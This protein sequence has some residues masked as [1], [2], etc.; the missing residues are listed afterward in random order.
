MGRRLPQWKRLLITATALF[1]GSVVAYFVRALSGQFSIEINNILFWVFFCFMAVLIEGLYWFNHFLNQRLPFKGNI[2]RRIAVQMVSG[3][4]YALTLRFLLYEL[5]EPYITV[6]LDSMFLAATWFLYILGS[7]IVNS[8]FFLD[9]FIDQWKESLIKAERLD[10]EKT[11]VQFDNLKNQLNPHFLFNALTS[12]NSLIFENQGLA[13]QFLQHLSKVYRYV[14]QNKGKNFVTVQ[15]ELDFIQNY[16]FLLRTRF[17]SALTISF[18]IDDHSKD[19][20]IV[21]V[22]LQILIEN[23]LKHNVVDK[24]R[25]LSIRIET[26]DDYLVV[27]NN[28]QVRKLVETSNKQGLENLKSLYKFLTDKPVQIDSGENQFSVKVPLV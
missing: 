5:G 7:V 25:P 15:T 10:K 21:P 6:K 4:I 16:V 12:L 9:F 1:V 26:N 28:L 2:P 11:Q 14:L 8:V 3:A 17:E 13:S 18:N 19:K 20:A 27:S 22:T 24:D 23:A